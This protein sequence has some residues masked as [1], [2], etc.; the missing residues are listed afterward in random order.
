MPRRA[1]HLESNVVYHVFNRRTDKQCLFDDDQSYDLFLQFLRDANERFPAR[2]HAYCL[3]RTHWHLAISAEDP[4]FVRKYVALVTTKHA[5]RFR[6]K[7]DTV[8]FGHVYQ[9][10]YASL[11]ID[12]VVGYVRLIRYIEANALASGLVS[13]AE[14]WRWSSLRER[15]SAKPLLIQPGPWSLPQ[16]WID[17]VNSPDVKIEEI[18]S[19]VGQR[20]AFRPP[21]VAFF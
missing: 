10:R 9:G 8:G 17:I 2:L 16:D 11:P 15:C 20:A 3:M 7:T 21:P 5:M 18:E 13:R 19:L 12:G 4:L 1:R 14:E 6:V